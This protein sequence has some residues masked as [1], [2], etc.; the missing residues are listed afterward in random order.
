MFYGK[1][2]LGIEPIIL[3]SNDDHRLTLTCFSAM[4]NLLLYNVCGRLLLE[5]V[6]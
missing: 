1:V 2:H 5:K 3:N 6:I 4:S